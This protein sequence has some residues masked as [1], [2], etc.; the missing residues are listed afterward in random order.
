[1]ETH[2][3]GQPPDSR[4]RFSERVRSLRRARGLTLRELACRAGFAPST[5]SKI[6]NGQ[7]SASFD[8]LVKLAEG[9][10]ID[11]AELFSSDANL[12]TTARLSVTR[13]GEGQVHGTGSYE[14]ELLCTDLTRK[15]MTPLVAAVGAGSLAEFGP[16]IRHPGEEFIHVLEGHVEL[17]TE[18]YAP[19]LLAP[20]DSA[21][22]DST[23]GHAL[24]RKGEGNAAVLWVCTHS[25]PRLERP[26]TGRRSPE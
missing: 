13:K 8:S 21:Y 16:L 3:D 23:M 20:G 22:F 7:L 10:G 11:F 24:L 12:A 14:Y 1:M 19:R 5:L 6:E 26:R 9:L 2:V 15:R 18:F 17:H 25:M 4:L